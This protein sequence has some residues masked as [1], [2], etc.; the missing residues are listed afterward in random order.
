MKLL[1]IVAHPHLE[2]SVINKAWMNRL[3]REPQI[4]VHDLYGT[5]P[6]K[7]IDVAKEQQLLTEHDRIVFQFPMYWYSSPSLLKEWQ[8][9]VLTHGWA[10]GSNGTELRGKDFLLAISIGGSGNNY[11]AGGANQFSV[12]ELVKPFQAMAN[13]TG[14]R[15]LPIFQ[16]TGVNLFSNKE[17]RQSADELAAYLK[18]EH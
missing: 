3:Q 13:L 16:K 11:Q 12:S 8:D 5:Y 1:D 6:N 2:Q 9:V 4:T 7:I 17:V 14:M 18:A 10:Y 15:F